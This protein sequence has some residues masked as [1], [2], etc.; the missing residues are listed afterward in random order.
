MTESTPQQSLSAREGVR[1]LDTLSDCINATLTPGLVHEM[2]NLLTGIYFNLET[3]RDFFDSSHPASEALRE[4]NQ[5]VER[6][7]E[8]LGRTAQIHL[9]TAEREQNY[10]DLESLVSS[11]LD[12]LRLIFPKTARIS[13]TKPTRPLHVFVPEYPLRVALLS[14]AS[15]VRHIAGPGKS[16]IVLALH[17]TESLAGLPC[18]APNGVAIG[19][20]FPATLA[21]CDSIEE[22]DAA[23][24]KSA[25]RQ[26]TLAAARQIMRDISG[27]L[28]AIPPKASGRSEVLLVLQEVEINL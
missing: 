2:N 17:S 9:N 20:S 13:I 14:V 12:L 22:I 23:L 3:M 26:V 19:L 28:H 8:L 1:L 24:Q 16:E 15:V 18:S 21:L 10:H 5:G 7:K 4:T 6:I 11:Q 25:P 27:D